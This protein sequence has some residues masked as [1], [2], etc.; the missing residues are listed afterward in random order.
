MPIITTKQK[1]DIIIASFGE[2]VLSRNEKNISVFCPN[3]KRSPKLAKKRKLSIC[4]ETGVYHCW[5]CETKGKNISYLAK[6]EGIYKHILEK[7][8]VAF[9]NIVKGS[10]KEEILELPPDF[11]LLSLNY[12]RKSKIAKK[13]LSSRGLSKEDVIKY[14]IGISN[15][16]NFINRIIF[17]S[18][19]DKLNLNFFLSRTYDLNQKI[20]YRNCNFSK[21]DIIFNENLIDWS[22]PLVLV[23]GVFDAVKV[24]KNVVC[25]L[26]SW[27]DEGF[28]L[29]R[30][31][32]KN[33]TPVILAPDPDARKKSQKIAKNLLTYC[34]DVKITNN[35]DKDFGEMTHEEAER[36]IDNA[37]TFD[38]TC[39]IRYLINDIKSGSIF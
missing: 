32:V 9:G 6:K 21:R 20:K 27:I 38:N 4:L 36:Y 17:P 23:E 18:F 10:E 15:E 35:L 13:Y 5:V 19:D 7:M 28:L 14:K 25:M 33:K 1:I 16:N 34:I 11:K 26:G 39:R 12:C 29:F 22:K 2:G 31:I 24:R 8:Y 37:Q 30:E 3:C